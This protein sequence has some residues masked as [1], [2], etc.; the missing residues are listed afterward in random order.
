MWVLQTYNLGFENTNV[1]FIDFFLK[2]KFQNFKT[3]ISKHKFQKIQNTNFKRQMWVLKFVFL[4]NI[5]TQISKN[6]KHKFQKANVGFEICVFEKYQ[7][8]NFKRQMS[9]ISKGK[10]QKANFKRQICYQNSKMWVFN[11][12]KFPFPIKNHICVLKSKCA[13]SERQMCVL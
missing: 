2:P 4:R 10:C 5:K 9:K 7:N 12:D 6:S 11:K 1:G 3:Q 13:F 8:T